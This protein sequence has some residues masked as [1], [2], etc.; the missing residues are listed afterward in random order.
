MERRLNINFKR[1][2]TLMELL[3][4]IAIIAILV[5]LL[6]PALSHVKASAKRTVCMNHLRQISLD[7]RMYADD[8]NDAAPTTPAPTASFNT[9]ID[10]LA[11]FK[12]LM[13]K[14]SNSNLFICPADIFYYSFE[15]AGSVRYVPQG[16]HE[17][18]I[19]GH[20]SYGFNGGRT[21]IFGTNA[22]GIAGRKLSSIKEPAKTILVAEMS[23]Y[24]PWSWHEPKRPLKAENSMFDG[25][26]N[27]VSFVDGH[28]NYIKMYWNIDKPNWATVFYEPPVGYDYTWGGD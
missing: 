24:F 16:F 14:S 13:E 3:V 25:S 21:D 10:G 27:V 6:L 19:S 17:Q 28:V 11:A 18:S 7:V 8:S 22:I 20:S 23:A 1:A 12:K 2:F 5:A 4:V 15:N 26:K 9:F